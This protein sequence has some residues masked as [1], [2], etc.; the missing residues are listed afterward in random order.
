MSGK[1]VKF[2]PVRVRSEVALTAAR[3]RTYA[4]FSGPEYRMPLKAAD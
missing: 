1:A 4:F 3:I 2:E